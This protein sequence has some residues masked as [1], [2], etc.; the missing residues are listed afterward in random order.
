MEHVPPIAIGATVWLIM[1]LLG[2]TFYFLPAIIGFYNKHP[3]RW[4][5]FFLTLFFAWS[6][7][8]WILLIV[9]ALRPRATNV[10]PPVINYTENKTVIYTKP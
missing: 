6:L 1:I 5:I 2:M 8:G 3:K 10:Q 9:W 4:L 7:I